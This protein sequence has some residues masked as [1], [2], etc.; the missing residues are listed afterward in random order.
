MKWLC[1]PVLSC[2]SC[3]LSWFACPIGVF[4][5]FSGY[6]V[7]PFLP[8]GMVLLAG[9]FLGRLLCG[10]VCPFGL[11][12]D[13]LH[14]I[15]SVKV[16]LPNWTNYIKYALLFLVVILTPYLWGE[17]TLYSFCRLCP[18]GTL[19]SSVP[20]VIA[21]GFSTFQSATLVRWLVLLAILVFAIVSAR[22]F[23]KALCPL[24]ALL[25]PLNYLSVWAIKAP[26]ETCLNCKKCDAA[27]SMDIQ[28]SVRI[29]QGIPANRDAECIVCH[30]CQT[31]C[32]HEN[33]R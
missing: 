19:Q 7:F 24:G 22:S 26:Q 32:I 20:S 2:H 14:K 29:N 31:A 33:K 12:Q 8:L 10:W 27:C 18:A 15:P 6:H 21:A 3:A 11:L 1:N 5:H 9:V 16:I 23:C 13:L 30:E 4:V 28:P 25:A 17:S